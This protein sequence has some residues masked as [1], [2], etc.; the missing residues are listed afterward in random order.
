MGYLAEGYRCIKLKIEPGIDVERVRAVREA[1]PEI[2]LGG[3]E[4]RLSARRRRSLPAARC[5]RVVDDRA[6]VASRGSVGA[7]ATS[8]GRSGPDI[9]SDE[10][11]RSGCGRPGG[12]RAR[13]VPDREHQAGASAAS[14]PGEC[15][16]S[17][18]S[19]APVWCGGMLETGIGRSTNLALAAPRTSGCP[20]T[21]ARPRGTSPRTLPSRSS[22]RRTG[23][24]RFPTDLIGAEPD[25]Q[26]LEAATRRT[27][28]F[29]KE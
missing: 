5:V 28:R 29:E 2:L 15:T 10:S 20:A 12:D 23:R 1:N 16:T 4:R 8:S 13:G 24:C 7:L 14:R 6:A 27:E 22:W 19:S 21:R 17:R 25:P 9:C 11:I 3:R 18:P 26:R